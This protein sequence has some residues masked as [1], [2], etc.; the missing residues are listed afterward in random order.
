[1]DKRWYATPD[2]LEK[3]AQREKER[4]VARVRRDADRGKRDSASGG[5]GAVPKK[6]E[7]PSGVSAE[8][9]R[10]GS[11]DR[12]LGKVDPLK[13]GGVAAAVKPPPAP[14]KQVDLLDF[15][16]DGPV[17]A[18]VPRPAQQWAAFSGGESAIGAIARP[19]APPATGGAPGFASWTAFG[20]AP[21]ASQQQQQPQQQKAPQQVPSFAFQDGSTT[22]AQ[23]ASGSTFPAFSFST[24]L[25]ATANANVGQQQKQQQQPWSQQQVSTVP[26]PAVLP[27][28][29]FP[30]AGS[31]G[32]QPQPPQNR[33]AFGA[34]ATPS[35]GL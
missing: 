28:A 16:S 20:D 34:Q 7:R 2:D 22:Q 33:A 25:P 35:G 9:A 26:A 32:Q 19:P 1:M 17:Q 4:E 15:L 11:L 31:H 29:G 12:G 23:P 6:P 3:D 27:K 10:R 21:A 8:R 24:N 13:A 5:R 18:Q 30:Q 14:K